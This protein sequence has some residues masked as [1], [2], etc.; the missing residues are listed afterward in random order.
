MGRVKLKYILEYLILV[1]NSERLPPKKYSSLSN[2]TKPLIDLLKTLPIFQADSCL[3]WSSSEFFWWPKSW[4]FGTCRT[5]LWVY[6]GK[7]MFFLKIIFL[8]H[9]FFGSKN[10]CKPRIRFLLCLHTFW[11]LCIV[12]ISHWWEK[13]H[14]FYIK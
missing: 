13:S 2:M 10:S 12:V 11:C 4:L 1:C 14:F 6:I 9:E 8:V 7:C 5:C 3:W